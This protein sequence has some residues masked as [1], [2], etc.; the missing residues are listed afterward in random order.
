[1][2][3]GGNCENNR[4]MSRTGQTEGSVALPMAKVTPSLNG[5]V[6]DAGMVSSNSVGLEWSGWNLTE[7]RDSKIA[8]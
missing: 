5:S 1:M 2:K 3:D 7:L 8:V 6:L 4:C